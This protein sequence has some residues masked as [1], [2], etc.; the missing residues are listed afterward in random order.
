MQPRAEFLGHEDP[1]TPQTAAATFTITPRDVGSE[2]VRPGHMADLEERHQVLLLSA[3]LALRR[4]QAS[5]AGIGAE[6]E[7]ALKVAIQMAEER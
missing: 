6:T 4:I 1:Q 5:G 3:K 7:H 2:A